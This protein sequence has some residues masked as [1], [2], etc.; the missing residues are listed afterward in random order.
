M[1]NN[2]TTFRP[3]IKDVKIKKVELICD[4]Y[5]VYGIRADIRQNCCGRKMNI[6]DYRTVA[7]RSLGYG[8]RKVILQIEKQRYVCPVCNKRMTSSIDIVDRNCSISNEVKDEI[9]RK[10]SEMKSFTQIGREE[11]TSIS[12]VMRIFHDIEVP[13]KELDY[14]TVYLDEFKGNADKEKYQLAIYDTNHI[15][16]DILKDRKSSTIREFLLCHKDSIKKVGMDMFMQF[17]NT[18]Y[19]CLPHADIVA[20]KYHV[21]RQANWMIRSEIFSRAYDLRTKFF[22]IFEIKDVTIFSY[23]LNNLIGELKESGIKECIK[24]GKTLSNWEKE[25]NNIQKYIIN[26]GFVEGKNNKIKVI[27]RLSYGIKKF[28]NLK[29]L[30]QI[31]N[32]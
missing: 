21:I 26:N 22:S 15:L 28:D 31:R 32:S 1:Q 17:R 8:N 24:L 18:V 2:F 12:T 23:E 19:S 14:E 20:D 9:R 6:H 30:I 4:T 7:I 3:E 11:N 27:K 16:I 5:H 29:K 25:I 13:H 10:L